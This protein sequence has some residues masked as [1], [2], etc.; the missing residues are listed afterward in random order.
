VRPSIE[1]GDA[2]LERNG[3]DDGGNKVYERTGYGDGDN[4][5][6]LSAQEAGGG[7]ER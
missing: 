5:L 4:E 7:D 6:R 3:T 2:G 1:V